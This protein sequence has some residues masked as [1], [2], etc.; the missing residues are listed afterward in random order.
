MSTKKS[1]LLLLITSVFFFC[2]F[3]TAEAKT[4]PIEKPRIGEIIV[5]RQGE[6]L[7]VR[8]EINASQ[9]YLGRNE[10]VTIT[11]FFISNSDQEV[12]RALQP[13]ILGGS[14]RNRVLHRQTA[15]GSRKN[16]GILNPFAIIQRENNTPQVIS[17]HTTIPYEEWMENA[18]LVLHAGRNACA[19]CDRGEDEWPL[20]TQLL[21][22]PPVY[23]LTY[24]EPEPEP[25]K[26]RSERHS[27]SFNYPFDR[28]EL[29]RDYKNNATELNK[30]DKV[31]KEVQDNKDLTVTELTI[32]G[33][34]SPEGS[35]DYNRKL[36]QRRAFSFADYLSNRHNIERDRIKKIEG[37]GEDWTGLLAAVESSSLAGREEIIR[38]I[39]EVTPPDARDIELVKIEG[40]A[41]YHHLLNN[42]YPYLRRTEYM[43]AY[44]VRAFPV[45]EAKTILKSNPRLL[46]L[47]EMYLVAVT[48]PRE[49]KEFKE[50]FDIAARLYPDDPI[51]LINSAATDLEGG[52]FVAALERLERVKN[53]PR[54]WN[55]MGV[56]YAKA[57]DLPK[58]TEFLKKAA[59]NG[60]PMA[61]TNLKELKKEIKNQ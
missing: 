16:V 28:Y 17:Y 52:N 11:P 49:S 13:V 7:V 51:A 25:V 29:L 30:V 4:T 18:S 9:L 26:V 31:I 2:G 38:I 39:R 43:I 19:G 54:A 22:Q 50:V 24:I 21:P 56:S 3:I 6:L 8:M 1:Y 60:D 59:D 42:L 32:E 48:Y 12:R 41:T 46:S 20:L 40:G 10:M 36:A 5:N 15:L 53:D 45:E 23:H 47:N 14:V 33:Y 44:N 27:A 34:A 57:G 35:F 37:V 58:A 55:N 61:A